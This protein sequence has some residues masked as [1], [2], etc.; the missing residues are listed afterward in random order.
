MLSMYFEHCRS[1]NLI[2]GFVSHV[3][4]RKLKV[5]YCSFTRK[6]LNSW[7][8]WV[9]DMSV[10]I[11]IIKIIV[12]SSVSNYCLFTHKQV[13]NPISVSLSLYI[14]TCW[15]GCNLVGREKRRD[16]TPLLIKMGGTET[17]GKCL[18]LFFFLVLPFF[19]SCFKH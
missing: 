10:L 19:D 11:I 16:L 18:L 7:V 8:T 1:G 4:L 14:I 3:S 13:T 2:H 12:M 17:E 9:A 5:F 15:K 6:S